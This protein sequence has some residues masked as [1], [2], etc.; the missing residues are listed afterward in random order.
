MI[1]LG[2]MPSPPN[3]SVN[4]KLNW[5]STKIMYICIHLLWDQVWIC[6][7]LIFTTFFSFISLVEPKKKCQ[8]DTNL[9]LGNSSW[10]SLEFL[11]VHSRSDKI[12]ATMSFFCHWPLQTLQRFHFKLMLINM[13][14]WAGIYKNKA[15]ICTHKRRGN[16]LPPLSECWLYELSDLVDQ[17]LFL[18]VV[19]TVHLLKNKFI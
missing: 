5:I 18:C 1:Q 3:F 7:S 8:N 12:L 9:S 11:T 17:Y 6:K 13:L 2:L 14:F 16:L 15:I 19:I 4:I 10:K